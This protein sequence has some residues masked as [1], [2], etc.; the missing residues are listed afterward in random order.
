MTHENKYPLTALQRMAEL[1]GNPLAKDIDT[2]IRYL[3]S[4]DPNFRFWAAVAMAQLGLKKQ[5]DVCPEELIQLLDDEN[6][7]VAAEAAYA[8]TCLGNPG[9]GVKVLVDPKD[10]T[11]IKVYYSLLECI[12]LDKE[13]RS[14]ILPYRDI[15]ETNAI[16]LPH[17]ENEDAG[18]MARGI[19]VN[20]GIWRAQDMYREQ[21]KQ[22]LKLNQ[23]RR[24]II[25]LP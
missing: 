14:F 3:K 1:A 4:D 9:L 6:P 2:I 21:Y 22:G 18:I 20:I 11:N 15:L 10:K 17:Q 7:H 24:P 8:C 25:P 12:S 5:Y 13:M 19:L 16:N 23:A